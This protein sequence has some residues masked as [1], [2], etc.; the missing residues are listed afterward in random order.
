MQHFLRLRSRFYLVPVCS[1][2]SLKHRINRLIDTAVTGQ[3]M[4]VSCV[5]DDLLTGM[6]VYMCVFWRDSVRERERE[7]SDEGDADFYRGW[8]VNAAASIRSS[9]SCM[10]GNDQPLISTFLL[11]QECLVE[12]GLFLLF[13]SGPHLQKNLT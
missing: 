12:N 2:Q 5:G 8:E 10:S 4:M 11:L 7:S 1:T 6:C 13:L 9:I 3:S